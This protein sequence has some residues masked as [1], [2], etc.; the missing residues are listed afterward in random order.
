[1][2]YSYRVTSRS[3]PTRTRHV[4]KSYDPE[5]ERTRRDFERMHQESLLNPL[6]A[7]WKTGEYLDGHSS[8]GAAHMYEMN[9]ETGKKEFKY[10]FDVKGVKPEDVEVKIDG[11]TLNIS[12][13]SEEGSMKRNYKR[14]IEIPRDVDKAELNASLSE[15]GNLQVGTLSKIFTCPKYHVLILNNQ[16]YKITITHI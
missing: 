8:S 9:P 3:V 16:A 2:S 14:S 15:S 4:Y 7:Q 1:M 12:C 13:T 10:T 6:D 5:L 11:D